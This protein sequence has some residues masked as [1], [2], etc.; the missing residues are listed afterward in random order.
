MTENHWKLDGKRALVTGGTK[1]IGRS[2]AEELMALGASVHIVARDA[3]LVQTCLGDWKEKGFPHYLDAFYDMMSK[4][5]EERQGLY[6][7][8]ILNTLVKSG[9]F[10]EK[11]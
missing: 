4:F 3:E 5:A 2:V 8:E 9:F 10:P 11:H 6:S 1:G 7:G